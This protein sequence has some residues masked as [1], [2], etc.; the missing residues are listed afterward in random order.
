M[1]A[2]AAVGLRY[3]AAAEVT[4][5]LHRLEWPCL[6]E[7]VVALRVLGR[8]RQDGISGALESLLGVAGGWLRTLT[9]APSAPGEPALGTAGL[10]AAFEAHAASGLD[11]NLG[12]RLQALAGFL[13]RVAGEAHPAAGCLEEVISRYGRATLESPP[14]VYVAGERTH[15]EA[16][17][18]WLAAEELDAEVATLSALRTAPIRDALVLLGPPARYQASQW[19]PPERAA[20]LTRW[21]LTCPPAAQVHVLTW[22]GHHRLDTDARTFPNSVPPRV[23]QRAVPAGST[24]PLEPVWVPSL[25]VD[26]RRASW[27]VD[28][29]PVDARGLRLADDTVAFFPLDGRPQAEVITWEGGNVVLGPTKASRLRVGDTL[30]FRPSRSAADD[31]LHRRADA[32][33]A[34]RHG[35]EAPAAAHAAKQELKEALAARRRQ[36]PI[37][38]SRLTTLLGDPGYARHVLHALGD[39]DYIG[40]EK[41]GAYA[42]LRGVLGLSEDT[43]RKKEALLRSLRAA[44][45]AAGIEI[46]AELLEVL[47]RTDGWQADV[48]ATGAATISAGPLLGELEI[49]AIAAIDPTARRLGRS[50]LGRLGTVTGPAPRGDDR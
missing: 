15:T 33:L 48:D 18:S 17:T 44:C 24:A 14:A 50:R 35:S 10:A 20:Q 27:A 36:D 1:T 38:L 42:A 43:G 2:V 5:E 31:E 40:P 19:C 6:Y 22:P 13:R 23:R 16:L 30:L 34:S 7:I 9:A 11:S 26:H 4:V 39:P 28:R 41:P 12:S 29:D 49:R 8:E 21:V 46:A 37:A 3:R 25:P 45:R 32:R 47:R